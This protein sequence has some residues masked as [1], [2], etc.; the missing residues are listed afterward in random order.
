MSG[1][2]AKET[3]SGTRWTGTVLEPGQTGGVL[4]GRGY[5]RQARYALAHMPGWFRR[6]LSAFQYEGSDDIELWFDDGGR[7]LHQVKRGMS[8][9][10]A[11]RLFKNHIRDETR[12]PSV[13]Y[14]VACTVP[15]QAFRTLVD[16][17]SL[18]RRRLP[19]PAPVGENPELG[20]TRDE[21][22]ASLPEAG[23]APE[24]L[25]SF[26]DHC[27]F[28]IFADDDETTLDAAVTRYAELGETVYGS[29][30]E[31]A[32]IR[33][34]VCSAFQG[35]LANLERSHPHTRDELEAKLRRLFRGA[36]ASGRKPGPILIRHV[37]V[38][39]V[40]AAPNL[41][42][43]PDAV[44]LTPR[45]E[46]TLDHLAL[47]PA[48]GGT[49]GHVQP[50]AAVAGVLAA[51]G[52]FQ[53]TLDANPEA[54]VVY[55]GI[56]HIPLA[57]FVGYRLQGRLV[58]PVDKQHHGDQRVG[59][60]VDDSP[61]SIEASHAPELATGVRIRVRVSISADVSSVAADQVLDGIADVELRL[62]PCPGR[63]SVRSWKQFA[64]V[65]DGLRTALDRIVN[66]YVPSELNLLP[67]C[68][69]SVALALG[70][71]VAGT[72]YPPTRVYDFKGGRF[73]WALNLESGTVE[74]FTSPLPKPASAS[75]TD[76]D[77]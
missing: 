2:D 57:S 7:E 58:V 15:S 68:S 37:S 44:R 24:E 63:G 10:A 30:P 55:F 48:I 54:P 14:V 8:P 23:L 12:G 45:A 16:R 39:S 17:L 42:G 74:H 69:P 66:R 43:A 19:G 25:G 75:E 27:G 21:L 22:V 4:G 61:V 34:H 28:V 72:M 36:L 73:V 32:D 38:A 47:P 51:Q 40:E 18:Y 77:A 70:K 46:I 65:Q 64:A 13:P 53:R 67:A 52:E 31:I 35:H 11:L 33:D 20:T 71:I 1:E 6:G 3:E 56:P 50:E 76:N 60:L 41:D 5:E 62:A 9:V 59:W 26:V 29:R 49:R